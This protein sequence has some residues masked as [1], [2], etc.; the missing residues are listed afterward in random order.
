MSLAYIVA[1]AN[2]LIGIIDTGE[3]DELCPSLCSL[4]TTQCTELLGDGFA[5][6]DL[7]GRDSSVGLCTSSLYIT[8]GEEAL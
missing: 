1:K 8:E 3:V 4:L 7:F 2:R 6:T 5:I